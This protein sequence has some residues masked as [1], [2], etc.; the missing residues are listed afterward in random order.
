MTEHAPQVI[1]DFKA[2]AEKL[3]HD[4]RR[5]GE[6]NDTALMFLGGVTCLL[7]AS[8]LMKAFADKG[9]APPSYGKRGR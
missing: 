7:G 2:I 3:Y 8:M 5:R 6:N 1:Y 4:G 9:H